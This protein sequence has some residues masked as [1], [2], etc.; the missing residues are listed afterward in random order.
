MG[1][2]TFLLEPW[3]RGFDPHVAHINSLVDILRQ[4]A[5]GRIP[6]VA[7]FYGGTA[8]EVLFIFQDP[9]PETDDSA[10]GSGFLCSENDDPPA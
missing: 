2:P 9:G 8:S 4:D 7:P 10:A 1:E 5:N 6:Y 3:E